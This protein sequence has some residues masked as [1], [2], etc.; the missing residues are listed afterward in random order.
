MKILLNRLA[1]SKYEK[2][3][4]TNKILALMEIQFNLKLGKLLVG[5][6]RISWLW[7]CCGHT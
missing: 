2:V 1:K 7:T 4:M 3:P 6:V 5:N